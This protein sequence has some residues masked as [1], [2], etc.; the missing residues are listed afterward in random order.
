MKKK[1]FQCVTFV[2]V[3]E[4][5]FYVYRSII[6]V[7][8]ITSI[9]FLNRSVPRNVIVQCLLAQHQFVTTE[10]DADQ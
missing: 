7:L 3:H 8:R 4:N 9:I 10:P 6:D 5:S 1:L 2:C